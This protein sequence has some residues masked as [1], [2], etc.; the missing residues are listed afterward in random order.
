MIN[1]MTDTPKLPNGAKIDTEE[2]LKICWKS[3][4]KSLNLSKLL[5]SSIA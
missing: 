4:L 2:T 3:V 5:N 1:S